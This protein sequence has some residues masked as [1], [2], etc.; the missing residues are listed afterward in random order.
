LHAAARTHHHFL[1][2]LPTK[3]DKQEDA[4]PLSQAGLNV[5]V[6]LAVMAASIWAWNFENKL[7]QQTDMYASVRTLVSHLVVSV[8]AATPPP[9]GCVVCVVATRFVSFHSNSI[10]FIF[11]HRYAT[12]LR[13]AR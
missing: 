4:L 10:P 7:K 11:F 2:P 12:Y 1:P 6:D 9:H 3:N 13:A 8:S 5:G